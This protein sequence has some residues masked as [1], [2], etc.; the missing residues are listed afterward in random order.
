[1]EHLTA[2]VFL[3]LSLG[4]FVKMMSPMRAAVPFELLHSALDYA[5]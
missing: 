5:Q 1:M 4:T 2:H 3:K